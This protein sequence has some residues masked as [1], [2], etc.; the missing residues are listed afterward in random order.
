[1]T[2]LEKARDFTQLPALF[3]AEPGDAK[4]LAYLDDA[5]AVS[6]D[7]LIAGARPDARRLL[8]MITVANEPVTRSLLQSEWNGE[9]EDAQQLRQIKLMLDNLPTLPPD[10]QKKC[11]PCRPIF[12]PC[13]THCRRRLP[14]GQIPPRCCVIWQPRPDGRI[15]G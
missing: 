2:T 12:M 1:M 15:P 8:W 9:E 7:Q 10:L 4:E 14:P 5:L 11:K 3:A 6:L 13:L